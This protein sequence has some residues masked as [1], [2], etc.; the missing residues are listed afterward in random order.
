VGDQMVLRENINENKHKCFDATY[1]KVDKRERAR[2]ER[3][4]QFD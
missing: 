3:G 2:D 4:Q 1:E